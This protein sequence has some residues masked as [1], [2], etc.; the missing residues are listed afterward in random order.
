MIFE[1]S[2]IFTNAYAYMVMGRMVYNFTP[3]ASVFKVKAWRFGLIFVLL[4]IVAFFVQAAGAIIASQPHKPRMALLGIH[5]Y[6]GGIGFQQFCIF[7]FLGLAVRFHLKLRQQALSHQRSTGFLLLWIEYAVVGLITV[8]IIFR[9]IEYAN[10]FKST[11]PMHEV[12]QYIFD[13]TLMWIASILLNIFHP[14]RLMPGHE[15]NLP[16]RKV[17][18]GLKK[19]GKVPQGRAGEDYLLPKYETSSA[20]VSQRGASIGYE[21]VQGHYTPLQPPSPP[22][23][24]SF[25]GQPETLDARIGSREPSFDYSYSH[26]PKQHV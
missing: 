4:D 10:G 3:S 17:R 8:R 23:A 12:Y 11:I 9:L 13:S 1:V 25:D 19:E 6:M 2:P 5:V 21:P 22:R 18:K 14:G 15:S 16:S 24:H 7:L 20:D 26:D